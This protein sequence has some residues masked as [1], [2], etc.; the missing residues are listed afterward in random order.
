MTI[1]YWCLIAVMVITYTFTGIAKFAK[2]GYNNHCPREYLHNLSGWPKR[3]YWAHINSLEV[4]PQFIGA[5]IIAHTLGMPQYNID[6]AA[7]VFTVLRL[8]YGIFYMLDYALTRSYCWL[9]GMFIIAY[10][11]TGAYF[12]G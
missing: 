4:L 8:L 2:G 1:A 9:G 6:V 5:L 11:I 3:A 10:L 7:I 12:H